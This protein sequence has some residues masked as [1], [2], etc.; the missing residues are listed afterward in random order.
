[1]SSLFTPGVQKRR[2]GRLH[3]E[4]PINPDNITPKKFAE[5]AKKLQIRML[6]DKV[7]KKRRSQSTIVPPNLGQDVNEQ[8][9]GVTSSTDSPIA[10]S[11]ESPSQPPISVT[12][13]TPS[14]IGSDSFQTPLRPPP[15][16][17]EGS[18]DTQIK[19]TRLSFG[20]ENGSEEAKNQAILDNAYDSTIADEVSNSESGVLAIPEDLA[21]IKTPGGAKAYVGPGGAALP[22]SQIDLPREPS[23]STISTAI[24]PAK[25][26][27]GS[28]ESSSPFITVAQ[29]PSI[30][31]AGSH[32][33]PVRPG[34][35]NPTPGNFPQDTPQGG[36]GV[37]SSN[38]YVGTG[39]IGIPNTSDANTPTSITAP[40]AFNIAQYQQ[41]TL[42]T[43][44]GRPPEPVG[45]ISGTWTPRETAPQ[46]SQVAPRYVF[47]N[48]KFI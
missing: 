41:P 24:T 46:F 1:M 6:S 11:F 31:P 16:Q 21:L 47:V 39:S 2:S 19:G 48:H 20:G 3:G 17:N 25:G 30:P 23:S 4:P 40:F 7:S 9:Q 13:E 28:L 14:S 34:S 42:R 36:P 22:K 10:I 18:P 29:D 12:L 32:T 8:V 44:M 26:T 33:P 45:P 37:H 15:T 27:T 43:A 5:N 38:V 35:H